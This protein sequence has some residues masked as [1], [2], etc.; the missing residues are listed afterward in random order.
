[1]NTVTYHKDTLKHLGIT[2]VFALLSFALASLVFNHSAKASKPLNGIRTMPKKVVKP[3][4]KVKTEKEI[5]ME[6]SNGQVLWKIY[7]L[8]TQRGKT[9]YCRLSG[10]GFGGFGVM[11]NEGNVVCYP[12]FQKAAERANYWFSKLSPETNLVNAL[13]TF[14]LGN[15]RN[16]NREIIPHLDCHY[17]QQFLLVRG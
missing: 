12:T 9:D 16:E 15:N 2:I 7:Q 3:V 14:N 8:E 6:Q 10:R 17:Y 11:D 4:T 13:C 1:M 5:V